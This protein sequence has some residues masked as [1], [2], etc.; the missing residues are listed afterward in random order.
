MNPNITGD[1]I[2]ENIDRLAAGTATEAERAALRAHAASCPDC[3]MLVRIH[4][5][6]ADLAG[7]DLDGAMPHDAASGMWRSVRER[8]EPSRT[9]MPWYRRAMTPALAAAVVILVFACGFL[10]GELRQLRG[11]EN[12]LIEELA[13]SRRTL[14]AYRRYDTAVQAPQCVHFLLFRLT[15][16]E[17]F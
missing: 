7:E 5:H 8:I 12:R 13:A 14:E 3:A 15:S 4:E 2:Q 17:A 16:W 1:D 10:L 6:C 11:R 9:R